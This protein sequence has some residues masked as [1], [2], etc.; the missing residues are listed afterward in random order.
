MN[1]TGDRVAGVAET[2]G[3]SARTWLATVAS[4]SQGAAWGDL[5][6]DGW[7]DLYVTNLGAN[8]MWRNRG[9]G[10]F[11]DVTGPTA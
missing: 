3:K 4:A 11:E 1:S 8:Q 2:S 5:D 9:D 7:V 10:T 6:L